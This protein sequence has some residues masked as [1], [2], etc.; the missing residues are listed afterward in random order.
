VPVAKL[1]SSRDFKYRVVQ[2]IVNFTYT[3]GAAPV[4]L[5]ACALL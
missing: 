4:A 1:F 3:A 2:T 5:P